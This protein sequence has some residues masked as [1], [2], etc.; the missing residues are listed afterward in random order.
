MCPPPAD[1]SDE[2][3]FR[4]VAEGAPVMVGLTD[5]RGRC[6]FCNPA[7]HAF[8]G[9]SE[10]EAAGV[11]WLDAVHPD[12]RPA[13]ER[14]Y[15]E[16]HPRREPFRVE[17]RLRRRDGEARWCIGVGVPRFGD[18]GALR[19]YVGS[20]VDLHERHEADARLRASYAE[21]EAVFRAVPVGLCVF[22]R[23]LR[24][25]R[26]NDRLAAL[27][28]FPPEAHVGRRPRD[29]LGAL[30]ADA[31]AQLAR[32]LESGEP[33]RDVVLE[34]ET[35]ADPGVRRTWVE[36]WHPIAGDDG[37]VLGVSVVAEDVT[38]R[39][40]ADAERARLHAAERAARARAEDNERRLAQLQRVTAAL[41]AASS[42]AD[43]ARAVLEA[44]RE[45]F[46]ATAATMLEVV[47]EEGE[48]EAGG[49]GARLRVVAALG[50][51]DDARRGWDARPLSAA[52]PITEA[53]RDQR[54]LWYRDAAERAA[55][56]DGPAPAGFE[57]AVLVPLLLDDRALGGWALAFPEP[58]A[59]ADD[60]CAFLLTLGRQAAQA[61]ER[62][63]LFEAEREAR[64]RAEALQRLTAALVRLRAL[65]EI[66]EF[67]SRE[68]CDVLGAQ[69]CWLGRLTAD[70]AAVETL[71]A[72][73]TPAAGARR[74]AADAAGPV[75]DAL[76]DARPRW[77]PDRA[78]LR[79]AYP[80]DGDAAGEATAVLP[81]VVGEGA[82]ARPVG[83]L[84]V[85]FRAPQPFDAESRAFL[86]ALAQQCAQ[87]IERA[88]LA[89]EAA[90]ALAAAERERARAEEAS[91]AKSGFLATMS[92]ELRTPLNAIAGHAEL[93]EL[94][95]HGPV[96]DAQLGALGRV[97]RAQ[98]LLLSR[99]NDVLNYARLEAGHVAFEVRPT[100]VADV[101][102]EVL[103]MVEPQLAARGL[104]LRVALDDG[105]GEAP[106]L[107]WADREKLGQVLLNLLSNA[108]KFTPPGRDGVPGRID[109]AL[110][111][112]AGTPGV[113]Y[114]LVRDTG[115][116]IPRDRQAA[117]FE[118]FV[119]VDQ[120]LTRMQ[121]GTGLGLAISRDLARGMGGELRVRSVEGEGATF[122][123]TLRRVD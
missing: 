114:V 11:G 9:Q 67:A 77:W 45:T 14:A 5:A 58:R 18:D 73:G 8:T 116:G 70:G 103:P 47:E 110:A 50:F 3:R 111:T 113:V 20:F 118:P 31:E 56:W 63:R 44:G 86:L 34:G 93:I 42:T 53:I 78:S 106:L 66:G 102:R 101:V 75:G 83:A 33:L 24:W 10:A 36:Q 25:V 30:G 112:R 107:A 12:D 80:H 82:A 71:G 51:S 41:S 7:W 17:C 2:A 40:R 91:L 72:H 13:V 65:E 55:R 97:Q 85:G 23:E 1:P 92:H 120:K 29:L 98:R 109:V 69:T 105:P 90:R 48:G 54:V 6:V 27:N 46:G 22:D 104:T 49:G 74:L 119:Q 76:R 117:V 79:R 59:F 15:R 84:R 64:R 60:E 43:V 32:V 108:I 89:D 21:L 88:R 35:P 87:A 26:V 96:T 95:I 52:S 99:I 37:A 57:A 122:T 115:I 123:V 38:E 100:P 121:E 61:L 28:G 62:A 4:A 94:G 16:A 81:L 39:Q 68:L 19:G